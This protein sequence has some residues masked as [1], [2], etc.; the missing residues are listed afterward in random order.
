M[1]KIKKLE[2][3]SFTKNNSQKKINFTVSLTKKDGTVV[4]K[5]I[6]VPYSEMPYGPMQKMLQE[7]NK[8]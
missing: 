4:D 2:I 5:P 7:I 6:E 1:A 3:K 8:L